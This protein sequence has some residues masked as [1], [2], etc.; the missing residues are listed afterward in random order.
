[1]LLGGRHRPEEGGRYHRSSVLL[2]DTKR[3]QVHGGLPV[4]GNSTGA[5]CAQVKDSAGYQPARERPVGRARGCGNSGVHGER[6]V[7]AWFV[8]ETKVKYLMRPFGE[9]QQP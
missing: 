1:R 3:L 2:E 9:R 6:L 7:A 8:R 5:A 4:H